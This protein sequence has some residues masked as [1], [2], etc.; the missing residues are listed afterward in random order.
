MEIS[1]STT[2]SYAV[3]AQATQQQT[4]VRAATSQAVSSDGAD[5]ENDGDADDGAKVTASRGQ[6]VNIKA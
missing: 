4:Q 6:K 5:K 1:S 3:R 2:A